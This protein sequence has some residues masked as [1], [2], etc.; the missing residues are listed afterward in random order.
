MCALQ[1]PTLLLWKESELVKA[2]YPL[3]VS[4][5]DA[6]VS[7][8]LTRR[9]TDVANRYCGALDDMT[10]LIEPGSGPGLIGACCTVYSCQESRYF[11]DASL[12]SYIHE[13]CDMLLRVCHPNGTLD[14]LATNFYTPA[15]FEIQAFCRGY[16]NFVRYMQGTAEECAARDHMLKA[17]ALLAKGCLNGGFHTP[18]HR[19]VECAAL[20]MCHNIFG[21]K[22][23]REKVD[24]YLSE[25]IDC[26]EYGEFTERSMGCY[27]PIN[28]NSMLVMA[29]EGNLPQLEE[30]AQRNLEL[31]FQ[32]CDGDGAIFTRNSRRQ[33]KGEERVYPGHLWYYLYLWAGEK[34]GN[35]KYLKFAEEMFRSSV[36]EGRGVPAPLWLY[37]EKPQLK[38]LDVDL[39]GVALPTSYHAFYPNSN[40]LRVRKGDFSYTLLANNPDFL[41]VKFGKATMTARMCS[42]FFAVAQFAPTKI[43]KTET[44]YRMTFRAHGEYKGLFPTPPASSDW[45]Q[46]DHSQRPVL[47]PCDLDYTL[48][49]EDQENGLT[50][51]IRVDNTPHV[52]FKLEFVV[53][54][55][56]RLETSQ[57]ILDTTAG[58]EL[59]IK[60]G[61][62][63]LE[64]VETG[65]EVTVRGL[66]ANHMYHKTMRGSV[67][68]R[69]DAFSLYATDWSPVNR[70]IAL[71]FSH[72]EHAR[73][74]SAPL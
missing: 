54:A 53:P 8:M 48:D 43:A 38:A 28:V 5:M 23:L 34:F 66:F 68:Q 51:R 20:L 74:I 27:N 2:H 70:E 29:E 46:M 14:F 12:L 60:Q 67:P 15:T 73:A 50:M 35:L 40:I 18:N 3:I 9:C 22:E 65:C 30:Y 31:T 62:A 7:R 32:Y 1:V 11:R 24:G 64:N 57:V 17:L 47:N 26:D 19:W 56:T 45:F 10:Y 55:G 4:A 52:P 44:G 39:S 63:R 33:D 36:M 42:S 25:G 6:G 72:R 49:V 61:D 41:H 37:L 71:C 16:K 21:W 58:G 59:A 69:K 13:A